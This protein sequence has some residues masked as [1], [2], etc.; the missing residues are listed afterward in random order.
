MF[1]KIAKKGKEITAWE[2]LNI[3]TR[4]CSHLFYFNCLLL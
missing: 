4:T 1:N 2:E 3:G